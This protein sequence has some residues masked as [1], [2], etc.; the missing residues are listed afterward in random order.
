MV[1]WQ[2]IYETDKSYQAGIVKAVLEDSEIIA[3]IINKQDSSYNMFGGQ[4]IFVKAEDVIRALKIIQD[5]I[6][7]E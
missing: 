3:V 6:T 7:F 4:E 5:E 2:K 1:R